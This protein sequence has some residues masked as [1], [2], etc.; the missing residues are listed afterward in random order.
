MEEDNVLDLNFWPSFADLMLSLVF[1][2]VLILFLVAVVITVGNVNLIQVEKKQME[3]VDAIAKKYGVKY[4]ELERPE[5]G[6]KSYGLSISNQQKP[7]VIFTNEVTLQR[8]SFSDNVLFVEEQYTISEK[9]KQILRIVGKIL[10]EQLPHVREIQIQGH[11]DIRITHKYRSNL[12]L[13]AYRAMAVFEFLQKDA[14]IHPEEHLMSATSFGEYKPVNRLDNDS[15]YDPKRLLSDNDTK[16]KMDQNR[17]IEL[18]LIYRREFA[19]RDL[20]QD[21]VETN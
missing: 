16:D 11:A 15:T 3:M 10:N 9:G 7:D 1:I 13:A 6:A 17:R 18:L 21:K 14:D 5:A 2:L 4:Q 12:E 20:N 19:V 8:I